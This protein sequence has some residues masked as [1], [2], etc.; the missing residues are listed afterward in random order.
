M[1]NGIMFALTC[2]IQ[3]G[4]LSTKMDTVYIKLTSDIHEIKKVRYEK[5]L[6]SSLAV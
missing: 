1:E 4:C 3:A 5:V 2:K 6:L